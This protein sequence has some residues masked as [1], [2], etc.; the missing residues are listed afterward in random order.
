MN[1]WIPRSDRRFDRDPFYLLPLNIAMAA[2]CR[3]DLL[4]ILKHP[5][6]TRQLA[7]CFLK[8]KCQYRCGDIGRTAVSQSG[9]APGALP[10]IVQNAARSGMVGGLTT[11]LRL[12]TG[13]GLPL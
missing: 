6:C 4:S 10:P 1:T 2:L 9:K 7:N 12:F 5:T 8:L 3:H 13:F 11:A